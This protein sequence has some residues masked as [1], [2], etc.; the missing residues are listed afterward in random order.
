V[1]PVNGQIA[2]CEQSQLSELLAVEV[3]RCAQCVSTVFFD[4]NE[5]K[6]TAGGAH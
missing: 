3:W 5:S 1:N 4:Q 6:A 2:N